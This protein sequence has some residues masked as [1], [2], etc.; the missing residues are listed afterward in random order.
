M[1]SRKGGARTAK[2][3]AASRRNLMLAR[4]AKQKG[5]LPDR[6]VSAKPK[7]PGTKTLKTSR[8]KNLEN[9]KIFREDTG[10]KGRW[11]DSKLAD[12]AVGSLSWMRSES[13]AYGEPATPRQKL[14]ARKKQAVAKRKRKAANPFLK[15][16]K[17]IKR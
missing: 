9:K 8:S 6:K 7:F 17:R 14:A 11:K 1:A 3:R 16:G 5:T 13:K 2:Q 12:G 15:G 4:K 10:M